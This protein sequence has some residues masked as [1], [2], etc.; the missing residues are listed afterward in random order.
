M[1]DASATFTGPQYYDKCLGPAW[2][3]PYASDLAARLPQRPPGA[4]LEVACGT[5]IV[6]NRLRQ[7]LDPSVRLVATDLSV[8]MLEYARGKLS[9]SKGIEWR[10]ADAQRLPFEDGAF[11]AAVCSFGL[12]FMPD[13]AAAL[14]EMRRVLVEGGP[15][16]FTVWDRIETNPPAVANAEAIESLFPGDAEIRFVAPWEMY[17]PAY[18]RS[19]LSAARF[20]EVRIE[21]KRVPIQ[22]A[23]PRAI[24]TGQILGTPRSTLMAKRGV[25][26]ERVIDK[27]TE[28]LEKSGGNPY[29][30]FSQ[31]V[32]VDAR[33]V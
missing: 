21:T 22:N 23:D 14:K 20:R 19:L 33:A 16:L 3:E 32:V 2:F 11:G 5:G 17:D 4:V 7:R 15:L 30:G 12:M 13:R 10:Q 25:A 28:A 18:L 29:N 1:A 24:A 6:T 8:P 31:A 26:L 9:E 27:V